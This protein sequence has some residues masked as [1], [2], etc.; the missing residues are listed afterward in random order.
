MP[1]TREKLIEFMEK[2]NGCCPKE[3]DCYH[4]KYEAL[5]D[6]SVYAK[7]DWLIENGVTLDNQ[8]SSSKWIPVTER[9]PEESDYYLAVSDGQCLLLPY[10][11]KHKA[12]N[13]F[14]TAVNPWRYQIAATHWMPLP[15]PPKGE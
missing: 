15:E 7:A 12:F 13:A 2:I 5:D 8:V 3:D 11:T 9:L 10:S 4:C 1:N 14:D 6:C